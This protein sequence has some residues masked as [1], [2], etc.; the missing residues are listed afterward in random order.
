MSIKPDFFE[1]SMDCPTI[2]TLYEGNSL[3]PAGLPQAS[4]P[5]YKSFNL[6]T[7]ELIVATNKLSYAGT[8]HP[9]TIECVASRQV[10]G[11][12]SVQ[13]EIV[14]TVPNG[15]FAQ[16]DHS[17][18]L[19]EDVMIVWGEIKTLLAFSPYTYTSDVCDGYPI[20]YEAVQEMSNGSFLPLPVEL[21]FYPDSRIFRAKKCVNGD[22]DYAADYECT[23]AQLIP[24]SK[25][26]TIVVV[27][28]LTTDIQ[29]FTNTKNRF[30]LT[31]TPDCRSDTLAFVSDYDQIDYYIT[32]NDP[33]MIDETPIIDQMISTCNAQCNLVEWGWNSYPNPPVTFFDKDSGRFKVQTTD[34]EYDGLR[35]QLKLS[36]E[37]PFS[38]QIESETEDIDYFEVYFRS[39]CRDTPM[40]LPT[41]SVSSTTAT[42]WTYTQITFNAAEAT[43]PYCG[44]IYYTIE[45]LAVNG[46]RRMLQSGGGSSTSELITIDSE[47][48]TVFIYG[49]EKSSD[50]GEI[51]FKIRGC[52]KNT[53]YWDDINCVSSEVVSVQMSDPC[54]MTAMDPFSLTR[55]LR[56]KKGKSDQYII[57]GPHDVVDL[58]TAA[59]GTGKCG[60][61]TCDSYMAD[62]TTQPDFLTVNNRIFDEVLE[63][64]NTQLILKPIDTRDATGQY[65][66]FLD[67]LFTEYPDLGVFTQQ[68]NVEIMEPSR[69]QPGEGG[70]ND[71]SCSDSSEEQISDDDQGNGISDDSSGDGYSGNDQASSD[72]SGDG[73][74]LGDNVT[75]D[76]TGDGESDN[77]GRRRLKDDERNFAMTE[78]EEDVEEKPLIRMNHRG[79]PARFHNLHSAD[80]AV[81]KVKKHK[82]MRE[83]AAERRL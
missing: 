5:A 34:Y 17:A 25:M 44:T 55:P 28:T 49:S 72:S 20:T 78:P 7:G 39:E 35:L 2:C 31:V 27:A 83:P 37:T 22:P 16:I 56:A 36:C 75:S 46:R 3:E 69:C 66:I 14:F 12:L 73:P 64:Y 6:F 29:V 58:A 74:S 9:L 38:M 41:P 50:V 70:T 68:I 54:E 59:D 57:P 48:N 71:S 52:L 32:K 82:K 43:N 26:Y 15:C 40:T 42:L 62:R 1:L 13:F 51:Q 45:D 67:C 76:T 23:D 18:S 61:V 60:P 24:Y 80:E 19:M 33:M 11:Y 77:L 53:L 21:Q 47:T 63:T 8:R 81:K 65:N 30:E 79:E 10:G 4:D